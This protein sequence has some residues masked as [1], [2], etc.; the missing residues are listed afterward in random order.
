MKISQSITISLFLAFAASASEKSATPSCCASKVCDKSVAESMSISVHPWVPSDKSLY[1]LDSAWTNDLGAS[2]KLSSLKGKP[3]IVIMFFANCSYACPILVYQM[4]QIEAALTKSLRDQVGFTLISFD[5]DR[6]SV[7]ALHQYRTQHSLEENR[8]TLL[9]G[10]RDDVQE[11][12]ALLKV[13]FKKDAGGQFQHSNVITLLNS[14]GEIVY[15][16]LGLNA[17]REELVHQ[18]SALAKK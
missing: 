15:Q 5:T 7:E 13:K 8:W 17:G 3:Q 10:N 2:V 18:T 1:Q 9:R 12:A 11:L 16:Q 4:Q 14:E 6:D